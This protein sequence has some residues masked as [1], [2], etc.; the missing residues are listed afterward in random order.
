M[1]ATAIEALF[2][3][4]NSLKVL[5]VGDVMLDSYLWG[6][7]TRISPEA[8]VPIVNVKNREKR[9]GG[10]ANVAL[11]L[12]AMGATPFLCALVGNDAE[13]T[14]FFDLLKENNLSTEGVVISSERKTTV[15][16]RI[17][18]SSQQLLRV[19]TEDTHDAN[20]KE[21][22]GLTDKFKL[23]IHKVDVVLFQDYNK[24]VLTDKNISNFID[25]AQQE[26]TPTIV[27]PKKKNFLAYKGVTI[28]KP[29]LKEL[30]EGLNVE[31]K[32]NNKQ[33]IQEAV[34]LLRQQINMTSALV[35]LS[36]EGVYIGN[37]IENS[38]SPAHKRD[39]A[40]VSGAGD[41]VVSVAALCLAKQTSLSF[42]AKLS[43]LAGGLVC[44]HIGVVPV[45]KERLKEEAIRKLLD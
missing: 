13:G 30:T 44:E 4:F 11:N 16:H 42:L 7:T 15:K 40:D 20:D 41:T 34:T 14:E 37:G 38:F 9:L 39:I 29:N 18:A 36:E 26:N 1:T 22:E 5:V 32:K 27:D 28:F 24:G 3:D 19:D 21:L 45:N 35:T 10:A 2:E 23:L 17:I 33:G 6:T 31:V 43:N 25:L 12:Q 8:P